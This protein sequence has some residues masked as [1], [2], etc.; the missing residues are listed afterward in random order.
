[1][2]PLTQSSK[3]AKPVPGDNGQNGGYLWEAEGR[4]YKE[5]AGNITYTQGCV[6]LKNS[7]GCILSFVRFTICKRYFN[8][9]ENRDSTAESPAL[10]RSQSIGLSQNFS[11]RPI[12]LF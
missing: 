1:M 2:N 11:R 7:S 9:K 3:L 8:K 4:M 10:E 12:K 6:Q 5:A